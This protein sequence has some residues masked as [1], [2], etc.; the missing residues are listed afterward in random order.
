M[1]AQEQAHR[2]EGL[3]AREARK[4]ADSWWAVILTA[5]SQ[6]DLREIVAFIARNNPERARTSGNTLIDQAL[7][8]G[9]QPEMGC[10]VPEQDDPAIN[11]PGASGNGRA[12]VP[13]AVETS[14]LATGTIALP[15]DRRRGGLRRAT[16]QSI[17]AVNEGSI[18]RRE[19]CFSFR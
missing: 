15:F 1:T 19:A 2:R 8:L 4:I 14:S 16:L 18:C 13:V 11:K 3:P 5:Q 17:V 9:M 7:L 12:T 10:V 6:E